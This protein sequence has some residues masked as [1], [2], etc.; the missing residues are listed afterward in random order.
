MPVTIRNLAV[1]AGVSRG[2]VDRVLN[3][4]PGA[5]SEA[6]E[7]VLATAA[8]LGYKPNLAGKSLAF[9]KKPLRIGYLLMDGQDPL[10]QEMRRG[11]EAAAAELAGF[12]VKVELRTLPHI[13]AAEQVRSLRILGRG[14]LAAL[15]LA[16]LDDPAVA[17]ELDRLVGRTGIPLVT[18][19]TDPHP[20]GRLCFV[21]QDLKKSG[22]VAGDLVAKLLGGRGTV[23]AVSGIHSI[24][25]HEGRLEGFLDILREEHSGVRVVRT[26]AGI[27]GN[28][29]AHREVAAYLAGNPR[30]DAIFVT[31]VGMGGIGRALKEAGRPDVRVVCYDLRPE[32]EALLREGIVDFTLTQD[33]FMQG[34]QPI[35]ILFDYLFNGRRPAAT[36]L[37]TRIEIMTRACL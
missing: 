25:S 2:T 7:R 11:V 18:C 24:R 19:N 33:P 35:K 29:D 4:R 21:G 3:G 34:Y 26:I 22:R 32:T 17:E 15:A 37:H 9:Q 5:S 27:Q 20:E 6:R 28:E 31:G 14:R 10:F 36:S 23:L 1:A 8:E 13:S 16:P 30:P 12:G